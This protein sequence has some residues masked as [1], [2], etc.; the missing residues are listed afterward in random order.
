VI[1]MAVGKDIHVSKSHSDPDQ[2]TAAARRLAEAFE[3]AAIDALLADAQASG[4]PIDG[5]DG[6][7]KPDDQGGARA[8]AADRD[9]P[10]P[11]L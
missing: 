9:D 3:P 7:L 10:P 6:L 8:G 4:T 2:E 5:V 1:D 11:G